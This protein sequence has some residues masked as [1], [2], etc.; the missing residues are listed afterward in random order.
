[1]LRKNLK[2]PLRVQLFVLLLIENNPLILWLVKKKN[3]RWKGK[4]KGNIIQL[5]GIDHLRT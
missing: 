1:M 2:N 5:I 3:K 4:R